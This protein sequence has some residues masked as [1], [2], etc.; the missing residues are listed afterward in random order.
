[1]IP[2]RRRL[3]RCSAELI[4][5]LISCTLSVR[6]CIGMSARAWKKENSPKLAK[7]WPRSKRI[8]RKLESKRLKVKAKKR[9]S[10]MSFRSARAHW[11]SFTPPPF[12]KGTNKTKKHK[13]RNFLLKN[14]T[15][16]ETKQTK[17]GVLKHLNLQEKSPW[18]NRITRKGGGWITISPTVTRNGVFILFD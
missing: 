8:T 2:T 4:I 12:P 5:N 3:R 16:P 18:I 9:D 11:N 13:Q 15:L 1:M 6:S 17:L 7:I 10:V 14:C